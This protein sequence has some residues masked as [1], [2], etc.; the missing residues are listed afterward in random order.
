VLLR[1]W[2]GLCRWIARGWRH[3]AL[4]ALDDRALR[5]VGLIRDR[6]IGVSREPPAREVDML[7]WRF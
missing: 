7:L 4:S 5:D 3:D 1:A 6:D 2:R